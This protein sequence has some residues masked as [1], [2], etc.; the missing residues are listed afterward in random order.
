MILFLTHS[1]DHYTIDIVRKQ[2]EALGKKVFRM[3]TDLFSHRARFG[4]SCD[5]SSKDLYWSVDNNGFSVR[6]IEAVWYRKL[7][8]IKPPRDLAPEYHAIYLQEYQ[9]M[10]NIFFASLKHVPW[11]NPIATDHA[12]SQDKFGQ[13]QVAARHG[14]DIPKSL[15]TNDPDR[16]REFF[17]RECRKKMIVK[18]HGSLSRSMRGD[19]PFFPTTAIEE[20]DVERLDVLPLCPMIFQEM[21]PKS[22]EL[23]IIYIDGMFY[24][25]KINTSNTMPGNTDWRTATAPDIAWEP[26]TLPETICKCLTAMMREM[27]LFFGALDMIRHQNGSYIFLEVNPQGEWGMLQRDL[28]YPIGET[29]AK[30]LIAGI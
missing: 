1:E 23:R 9:T 14:L 13:L 3:N 18:L 8:A 28:Q 4:Y 24:T 30:K 27:G 19:T 10:R 12:I 22:Y 15:F 5:N 11:M 16:A 20:K 26:Y 2:C 7:W 17:Y 29:I 25:G 21:I 6:D